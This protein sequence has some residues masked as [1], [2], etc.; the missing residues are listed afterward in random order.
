MK[1]TGLYYPSCYGYDAIAIEPWE[2][3]LQMAKVWG[4]LGKIRREEF[5][6]VKVWEEVGEWVEENDVLKEDDNDAGANGDGD[7]NGKAS[8]AQRSSVPPVLVEERS[9]L[10]AFFR[11]YHKNK[12]YMMKFPH[13]NTYKK[14]QASFP[15]WKMKMIDASYSMKKREQEKLMRIANGLDALEN[16][17]ILHVHD[18]DERYRAEGFRGEGYRAGEGIDDKEQ[19][20]EDGKEGTEYKSGTEAKKGS[21]TKRESDKS[22][23]TLSVIPDQRVCHEWMYWPGAE[24]GDDEMWHP[25]GHRCEGAAVPYDVRGIVSV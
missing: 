20:T 22:G 13:I 5:D 12:E 23:S 21:Q 25:E 15:K 10:R 4:R 16:E 19:R 3:K 6:F 17:I 11:R 18:L 24:P 9:L 14:F 1:N 2:R 8:D 7:A